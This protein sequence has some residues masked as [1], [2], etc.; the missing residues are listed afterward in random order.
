MAPKYSAPCSPAVPSSPPAPAPFPDL[1]A[2]Y[3]SVLAHA[4]RAPL[5]V[6]V[7][8]AGAPP[9]ELVLDT[10]LLRPGLAELGFSRNLAAGAPA[11]I[12]TI[13]R[14][15]LQP[16]AVM[17]PRMIERIGMVDEAHDTFFAFR[18]N[19]DP[20]SDEPAAA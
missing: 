10:A 18:C 12:H 13:A 15:G 11:L 1:A 6:R 3:D 17:A 19:D 16:L 5:I 7:P 4:Q 9:G 20:P 2:D 8:R 14:R